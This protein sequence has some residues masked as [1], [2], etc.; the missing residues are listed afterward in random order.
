MRCGC[1][2]E[3]L[4]ETVC[5]TGDEVGTALPADR[6]RPRGSPQLYGPQRPLAYGRRLSSKGSPG[7]RTRIRSGLSTSSGNES[8]S[9]LKG[10]KSGASTQPQ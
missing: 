7:A 3:S 5:A 6:T 8:G 2:S 4:G 10:A 9:P 1:S